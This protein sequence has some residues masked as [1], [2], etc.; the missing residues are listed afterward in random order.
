MS[1]EILSQD[2]VGK[3]AVEIPIKIARLN[4]EI[5]TLI[6]ARYSP[7]QKDEP[8]LFWHFS[9]EEVLKGDQV[10]EL[11]SPRLI[12]DQTLIGFT[13]LVEMQPLPAPP[14]YINIAQEWAEIPMAFFKAKSEDTQVDSQRVKDLLRVEFGILEGWVISASFRDQ[15]GYYYCGVEPIPTNAWKQAMMDLRI[16]KDDQLVIPE[17]YINLALMPKIARQTSLEISAWD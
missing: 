16:I 5:K 4:S 10:R 1:Q 7:E 12:Y 6:F 3:P 15:P 2:L 14:G 13:S 8:D 17:N 11:V 9:R